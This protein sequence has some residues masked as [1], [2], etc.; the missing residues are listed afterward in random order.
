MR[1]HYIVLNAIYER[2]MFYRLTKLCKSDQ[3]WAHAHAWNLHRKDGLDA[4]AWLPNR[5]RNLN[6][7]RAPLKS[8]AQGTNLFKRAVTNQRGCPCHLHGKLRSDFQR[9]VSLSVV[10][11]RCL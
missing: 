1:W 5:Y 4:V 11:F 3:W 10:I 7:S 8:Q 2:I 6:I 9:Y